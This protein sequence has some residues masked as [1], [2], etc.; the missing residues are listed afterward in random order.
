MT[1]A[2]R[3]AR[4]SG[5][6]KAADISML[7]HVAQ[8]CAAGLRHF[9]TA[10]RAVIGV[11]AIL[12]FRIASFLDT[13]QHARTNTVQRSRCT[14]PV[15]HAPAPSIVPNRTSKHDALLCACLVP[16][17]MDNIGI[18]VVSGNLV[19]HIIIV[20]HRPFKPTRA[21]RPRSINSCD[22]RPIR[23]FFVDTL[24]VYNACRP[25]TPMSNSNQIDIHIKAWVRILEMTRK[26]SNS[27]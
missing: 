14:S 8:P 19:Y 25:S 2:P 13:A 7:H 21:R 3:S 11:V 18:E 4:N 20:M 12:R 5:E 26:S 16:M 27:L 6:K 9:G 17:P 1:P 23:L 15:V 24:V 10:N 22:F